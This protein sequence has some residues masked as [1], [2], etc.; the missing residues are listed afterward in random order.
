MI[1]V[2]VKDLK[3]QLSRYLQ[4][5]KNGERV[6]IT[7]HN[8]IIAELSLP[9]SEQKENS[10]QEQLEK[11]KAEGK[12]VL[13]K[14]NISLAQLPSASPRVEWKEIYSSTREDRY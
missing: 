3:N 10:V 7:E 11:L 9:K 5:V 12:V 8:R 14:R 13:A 2:G 4:F 1:S 6:I